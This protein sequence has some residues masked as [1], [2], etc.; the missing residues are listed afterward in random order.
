MFHQIT[1]Y[2][3]NHDTNAHSQLLFY[4]EMLIMSQIAYRIHGDDG[5]LSVLKRAQYFYEKA[6]SRFEQQCTQTVITVENTS[7]FENVLQH[8]LG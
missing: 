7:D 8:V 6:K 4:K 2:N 3:T 1:S 5:S